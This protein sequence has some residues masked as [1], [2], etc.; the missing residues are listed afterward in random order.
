MSRIF[1]S[2]LNSSHRLPIKLQGRKNHN[3]IAETG[4]NL[5]QVI[6][7]NITNK[8]GEHFCQRYDSQRTQHLMRK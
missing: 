4:Q 6:T 2:S 7:M 3:Y 5:D 8:T 1:T